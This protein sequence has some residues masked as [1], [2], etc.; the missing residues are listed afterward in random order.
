M[1]DS[2][3]KLFEVDANKI[4]N[5]LP[6]FPLDNV[7]LL[8]F[9]KLP[10]NIFEER[11]VNLVNDVFN[12]DKLMGM[13]QSKRKEGDVFNV[14][15][16]G[17]ISDFQKSDDGRILINLS[18]ITRFEIIEEQENKKLYREFKV[19]YKKF[20]SDLTSILEEVSVVSLMEKIKIFF[21]KN[22][23]I[24][25]CNAFEHQPKSLGKMSK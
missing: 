1:N 25:V 12:K 18:G 9:G 19:E 5:T 6:L 22:D 2:L 20:S 16:L 7:L 15:C 23:V 13:I 24:R 10:L 21:R 8:P 14:G 3:K 11:Y 17:K 4:P